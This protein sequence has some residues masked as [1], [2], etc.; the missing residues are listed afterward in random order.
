MRVRKLYYL[1]L[2]PSRAVAETN[3]AGSGVAQQLQR[4]RRGVGVAAIAAAE[5]N[6]AGGVAAIAVAE[7]DRAGGG[8]ALPGTRHAGAVAANTGKVL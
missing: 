8:V 2:S 1:V 5:T 4:T 7:M 3:H 6:R